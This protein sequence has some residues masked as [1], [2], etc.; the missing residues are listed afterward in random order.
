MA[1][2]DP[3]HRFAQQVDFANQQIVLIALQQVDRKKLGSARDEGTSV[4]WHGFFFG[5]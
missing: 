4:V 3:P 2:T 5:L 1:F